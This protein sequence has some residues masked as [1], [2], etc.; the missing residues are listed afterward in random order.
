MLTVDRFW[1]D[2][3]SPGNR[4]KVVGILTIMRRQAGNADSN[5]NKR[6]QNTV[7]KSYI[8]VIG[9]QSGVSDDNAGSFMGFAMPNI[10]EE[11]VERFEVMRRDPTVYEQISRS[12]A[13]A[14][15]GHPDIKKA[16]ACLL[17]GGCPK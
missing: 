2:K 10:T 1:T 17:F 4:V 12:I 9:I 7:Q 16:I 14:I 5:A 6:V 11:D 13:P 8:R 15:F 3:C